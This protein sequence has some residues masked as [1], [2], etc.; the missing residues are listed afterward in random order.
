MAG[1]DKGLREMFGG[2]T[3]AVSRGLAVYRHRRAELSQWTPLATKVI[4]AVL[5]VVLVAGWAYWLQL[6]VATGP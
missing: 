4:E 1:A 6:Y 2:A 3:A 5:A